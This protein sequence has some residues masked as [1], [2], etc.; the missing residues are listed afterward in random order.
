[1]NHDSIKKEISHILGFLNITYKELSY[2][3][4]E[5]LRLDIFSI[6]LGKER[7]I[8]LENQQEVLRSFS[9]ILKNILEKKF[10]YFKDFIIDINGQ[11]KKFI[12]FTKEK[13][14]LA[15]ERVIFFNKDYEFGPLNAYERMLI[16]SFLKNKK[17][18]K[19]ES[20]GEGIHRRLVVKKT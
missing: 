13:A 14:A 7:D 5:D 18:I 6:R 17:G 2:L 16:H 11:Q 9:F 4:D 20:F 1:M 15:F 10:H 8:F 19:T 3:Y 12:D